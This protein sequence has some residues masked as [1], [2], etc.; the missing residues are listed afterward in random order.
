MT[1]LPIRIGELGENSALPCGKFKILEVEVNT[2]VI[3]KQV[4]HSQAVAKSAV[5]PHVYVPQSAYRPSREYFD[6]AAAFLPKMWRLVQTSFWTQIMA[7][8]KKSAVQGWK[9]HVSATPSSAKRTLEKVTPVCIGLG[10][11]F[12]FASDEAILRQLLSKN[13]ARQ[14]SGKFITIYPPTEALFKQLLEELYPVLRDEV[15][16]YILS[17]RRYKDSNVLHYRYGGFHSFPVVDVKGKTTLCILDDGYQFIEDIRAPQ[18][19]LPT[20]IQDMLVDTPVRPS[21]NNETVTDA[22]VEATKPAAVF[23]EKYTIS[24]VI[25][26]SNSGGVYHAKNIENDEAVIIKESRPFTG[27]DSIGTDNITRLEKEHRI[28]SKISHEGIAPKAYDLFREWEHAF[29][30]LEVAKGVTLRQ[31]LVSTNPL[32]HNVASAEA[33][34]NWLS[35]ILRISVSLLEM[36]IKL[37]RNNIVFGDLS[38]NNV[39]I[40]AESLTLK[41]IDF[42]GAFEPGIDPPTNMFTPGY[43]RESRTLRDSIDF[44]D[45]YYALG[46][47]LL[48]MLS[49]NP[50]VNQIN[51]NY[52]MQFIDAVREEVELPV[53]FGECM[54]HLLTR[55]DADLAECIALLRSAQHSHANAEIQARS[56][57][58][59]KLEPD[60]DFCTEALQGI[61]DYNLSVMDTEDTERVF[62]VASSLTDVMAIDHG[63]LGIAYAWQRVKG[64]IPADFTTW[65]RKHYRTTDPR[66]GLINGVSGTAWILSELGHPEPAAASMRHAKMNQQLYQKMSLGFGAAGYGL[67]NLYFWNK[68]S[69]PDY[70]KEA[71]KIADIICETAIEH[72]NGL[73][74]EDPSDPSGSAVGW[75]EGASGIALFLLY[76]YCATGDARYLHTGERG[77]AYDLSCGRETG[78]SFGFPRRSA[79]AD[80]I[81]MPYVDYGTAGVASV[82]LRYYAVTGN[83]DYRAFAEKVKG[84]VAHKFTVCPGLFDGLAGLG[85]YLLDAYDFLKDESYLGLA[86]RVAQG[87]K[88]FRIERDGG[89]AFPGLDQGALT[90]DYANGSAGIALFLHRLIGGGG[91]F[92]FM[93]DDLITFDKIE[94][95]KHEKSVEE[96]SV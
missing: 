65:I 35:D 45:D 92:N 30:A 81:L 50:T 82:V 15:G 49:P 68:T 48:A 17:D 75:L 6:C 63:M 53:Q 89:C 44:D 40:D 3:D 88:L 80:T 96:E 8:D 27:I 70:L 69:E 91:N 67:T 84:S 37:H 10:V 60:I 1:S 59:F 93:L 95:L 13:C 58:G 29:L 20:F 90:C 4:E 36:V 23:G 34:R 31:H 66:P 39:I 18:F 78:G 83:P 14:S 28:L 11:E 22:P 5:D 9:I 21:K 51:E 55:S 57:E 76:T 86:H 42:E 79:A 46:N 87:I 56:L 64:E 94:S 62:P 71:I 43:G 2:P 41:L 85:N 25:K 32:I 12:K 16:P 7:P 19:A 26:F 52:A 74:W 61:F 73:A 77:L 47:M 24:S 72:A 33:M 38:L 54:M